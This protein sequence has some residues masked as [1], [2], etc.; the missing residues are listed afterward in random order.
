[1]TG[2]RADHP[3]A[4]RARRR[5]DS[6]DSERALVPP[7]GLDAAEGG[8][9]AILDEVAS[10]AEAAI[11]HRVPPVL[12]RVLAH[13]P[14]YIE[15]TWRKERAL[16]GDGALSAHDKRRTAV[17]VAMAIR[18]RYLIEYNAAILRRA[19]TTTGTSSRFWA[20]WTTTRR[21]TP[22]PKGCRSSPT[23]V[24]PPDRGDGGGA[25]PDPPGVRSV[26]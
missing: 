10:W 6:I 16:M 17:G 18:G 1:M 22:S 8:A 20:W 15:A 19:E 24:R 2:G 21:S 9:K 23:S 12:W 3:G 5:R 11:G 26:S 4:G 14:P 25:H 7:L 13:N